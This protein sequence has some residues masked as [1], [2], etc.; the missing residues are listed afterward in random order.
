M[1]EKYR[2]PIVGVTLLD[3]QG[4]QVVTDLEGCEF[5]GVSL[6]T[7]ERACNTLAA[8][9]QYGKWLKREGIQK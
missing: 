2:K 8:M 6:P 3:S 4:K 7:P 5:K 9:V 1:M